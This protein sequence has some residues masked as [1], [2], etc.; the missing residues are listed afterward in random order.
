MPSQNG[1]DGGA[2]RT[3]GDPTNIARHG[4]TVPA[5]GTVL[6]ALLVLANIAVAAAGLYFVYNPVETIQPE[7]TRALLLGHSAAG[8][9][10]ALILSFKSTGTLRY[11]GV[12]AIIASIGIAITG[13]V[14]FDPLNVIW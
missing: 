11:L 5:V 3:C 12:A 10:V 13:S 4:A 14:K 2:D 6:L 9:F 7:L 1:Y 8:C